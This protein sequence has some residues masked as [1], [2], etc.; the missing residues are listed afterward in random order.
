M[1]RSQGLR[2]ARRSLSSFLLPNPH[3]IVYH[4]LPLSLCV[5]IYICVFAFRC[6]YSASI[7]IMMEIL[8]C[9]YATPY[10]EGA[11]GATPPGCAINPGVVLIPISEMVNLGMEVSRYLFIYSSIVWDSDVLSFDDGIQLEMRSICSRQDTSIIIQA[12]QGQ[13]TAPVIICPLFFVFRVL[14]CWS[15]FLIHADI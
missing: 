6:A 11:T 12:Q 3:S 7:V 15:S 1:V 14:V 10:W 4:F 9:S 5:Y 2:L 8:I 13:F